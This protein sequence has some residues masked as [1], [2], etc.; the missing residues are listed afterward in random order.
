[1]VL[2]LACP[3]ASCILP[4]LAI[5]NI[6]FVCAKISFSQYK[7]QKILKKNS[8]IFWVGLMVRILCLAPAENLQPRGWCAGICHPAAMIAARATFFFGH[9][10]KFNRPC[11]ALSLRNFVMLWVPFPQLAG[12]VV[13]QPLHRPTPGRRNLLHTAYQKTLLVE[14]LSW[15]FSGMY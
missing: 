1:V 15:R 14:N 12:K 13:E 11:D 6:S 8:K 10:K 9:Y 4:Y 7:D 5:P 3:G 2:R